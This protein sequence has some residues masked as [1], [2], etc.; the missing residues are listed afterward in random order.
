M[1]NLIKTESI[2]KYLQENKLSKTKFCKICKI[3]PGTFKKI[4]NNDS[5]FNLIALFKI[6]RVLKIHVCEI[7]E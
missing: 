7:F 1:K 2:E 3:S 4:M 6:A 5:N